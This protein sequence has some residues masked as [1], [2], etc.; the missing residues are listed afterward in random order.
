MT[1]ATCQF[2]EPSLRVHRRLRRERATFLTQLAVNQDTGAK[3]AAGEASV[4][5]TDQ[6]GPDFC[7]PRHLLHI[8]RCEVR[9][10]R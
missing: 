8:F 3:P 5:F 1:H 4:T 2:P 9:A 6:R 10:W 7:T